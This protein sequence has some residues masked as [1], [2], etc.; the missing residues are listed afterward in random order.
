MIQVVPWQL[1]AILP[2]CR[3]NTMSG[4]GRPTPLVIVEFSK[5]MLPEVGVGWLRGVAR[6]TL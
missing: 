3:L 2:A 4:G 6:L 5:A 1:D